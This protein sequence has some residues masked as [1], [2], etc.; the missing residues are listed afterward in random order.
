MV[1]SCILS[2]GCSPAAAGR[3]LK[4]HC[5]RPAEM[6]E[7]VLTSHCGK[8]SPHWELPAR[9]PP[10]LSPHERRDQEQKNQGSKAVMTDQPELVL[11][12]GSQGH[13]TFAKLQAVCSRGRTGVLGKAVSQGA[14]QT[15]S[16]P[17]GLRA[18]RAPTRPLCSPRLPPGKSG[19]A[20]V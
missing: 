6:L 8:L 13:V 18:R 3:K 1:P 12:P 14:G 10:R 16:Q 7:H 9:V 20:L 15:L 11:L 5:S 4:G 19:S 17:A 2:A